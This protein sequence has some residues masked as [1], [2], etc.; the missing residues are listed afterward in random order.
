MWGCECD[1]LTN[2][3]LQS[4]PVTVRCTYHSNAL[5]FLSLKSTTGQNVE[6]NSAVFSFISCERSE[7]GTVFVCDLIA[8]ISTLFILF[9]LTLQASVHILSVLWSTLKALGPSDT[10][11]WCPHQLGHGT[12]GCH[13]DRY[14]VWHC[15]NIV[16]F[17][18]FTVSIS[19]FDSI[20]SNF[21]FPKYLLWISARTSQTIL[22]I[23][24]EHWARQK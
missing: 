8:D 16:Q 13:R 19:Y 22:L 4:D 18:P 7:S 6:P 1:D 5:L 15:V 17:R 11:L 12:P 20:S 10:V 2:S 9:N 21:M 14:C 23:F 24:K 3:S